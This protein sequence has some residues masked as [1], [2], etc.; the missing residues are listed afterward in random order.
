MVES[1]LGKQ[2]LNLPL[3]QRLPGK[4]R[5]GCAF[6]S[7]QHSSGLLLDGLV[8]QLADQVEWVL[9]GEVPMHLRPLAKEV[10]DGQ[11]QDKPA[12]MASL[13]L[14]IA[15]VVL[16]DSTFDRCASALPLLQM[17]ACG[18]AVICSDVQALHGPYQVTRVANDLQ[19]WSQALTEHLEQPQATRQKG[20]RLRQQVIEQGLLDDAYLQTWRAAWMPG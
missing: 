17:G 6:D 10:H 11:L 16:G 13:N 19:A 14:D 5:V 8:R 20:A 9:W 15:L 3:A 1:R 18:Y 12:I 4:P 7:R 2:W